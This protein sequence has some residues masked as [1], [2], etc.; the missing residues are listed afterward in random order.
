FEMAPRFVLLLL[1]LAVAALAQDS[2]RHREMKRFYSWEAKRSAP[3]GDESLKEK[4]KFYAW[5]GKRSGAP[6]GYWNGA[7]SDLL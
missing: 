6:M 4:R 7:E 3:L 2:Q 5:A 1:L